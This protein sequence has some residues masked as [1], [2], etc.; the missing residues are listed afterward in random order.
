MTF[1]LNNY[2]IIDFETAN[3]R[4][5]SICQIGMVKV[6]SGQVIDSFVS[7]VKPDPLYFS[8]FN[9]SIHGISKN[10][11]VKQ[12]TFLQLWPAINSFIDN[13]I[14][15]AHFAQF[16]MNCLAK[17]LMNQQI[18]FSLNFICSCRLAQEL[19]DSANHKL[20]YLSQKITNYDY[21]SHDALED[22]YATYELMKYLDN[23]YDVEKLVMTRF[24][25]GSITR[26]TGYQGFVYK[27]VK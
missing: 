10:N 16:D 22:C 7:L 17:T 15:V 9:I 23:N 19:I 24:R 6:K 1:D 2:V 21:R 27:K 25:I 14:L 8:A 12:P 5:D 3:S 20:T 13:Y 11:V 4:P 18:D 26:T